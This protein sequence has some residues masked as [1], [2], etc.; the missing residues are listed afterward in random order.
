MAAVRTWANVVKLGLKLPET[1]VGT[2]YGTPALKV[3]NKLIARLKEDGVTIVLRMEM[4]EREH[5]LKTDPA[6][7]FITDHY[8]NYP[9]VLVR[10]AKIETAELRD[11]LEQ[12]W[13]R[14]APKSVAK[15]L[16]PR[17]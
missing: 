9:W 12:A 15:L 17:D 5:R 1:A 14:E 2:S 3:K 4:F 16:P 13:R 6:V 10:L 7:F 11:L 8:L